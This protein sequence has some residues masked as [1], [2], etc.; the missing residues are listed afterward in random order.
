M[1]FRSRVHLPNAAVLISVSCG[2]FG[3]VTEKP[4]RPGCV[5]D[6]TQLTCDAEGNATSAPCPEPAEPCAVA[7]CAQGACGTRPAVGKACGP[8]GSARCNEG[9][10]C[11][12]PD[13]ELSA[14][15]GHTCALADDGKI[16]CWGSNA[17]G[18]VGAAHVHFRTTPIPVR[19]LPRRA[20]AVSTGFQ[21]S[22]ALV[23]GGDAYCWGDNGFG[24]ADPTS[25]DRQFVEPRPILAPVGFAAIRAAY[26][27]T[28]ALATDGTVFCWGATDSGQC[29]VDPATGV[30]QVGP[31]R[32]P[33]LD[34]VTFIETVKNHVCAVRSATPSMVCW[35][36][37]RYEGSDE[38]SHKLGP[39]AAD[40]FS[41]NPVSVDFNGEVLRI[42]MG[43]DTTYAV[44]TDGKSYGFG[45]N[46][47]GR[48]GTGSTDPVVATPLPVFSRGFLGVPAP[49]AGIPEFVRSGSDNQCVK[50]T[51]VDRGSHYSCWGT[52]LDGELGLGPPVGQTQKYATPVIVLPPEAN[53]MAH[54]GSHACAAVSTGERTE[55]L[56]YGNGLL[57]GNPASNGEDVL[58]P[59][60]VAWDP[61][62]FEEA[63]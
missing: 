13:L 57:V 27:H 62:N 59:I 46:T 12:G 61:R 32:I 42:G 38:L 39:N 60:A 37:N 19:G 20:T 48:L 3:G 11:L 52:D 54:G 24:Q 10:A 8:T 28:C 17:Y 7:Q 31:T 16:W 21:H 45:L 58:N 53:K 34:Q 51:I 35:G 33:N 6:H 41:A 47:G 26:R 30:T 23:V 1:R 44:V 14:A 49:L 2:P 50:M 40:K 25:S 43:Y 4:C 22:C 55:I 15:Y 56:C 5:D 29:G 9:Y 36:D 63:K 18:Q